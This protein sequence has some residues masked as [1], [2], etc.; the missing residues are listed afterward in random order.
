MGIKIRITLDLSS[1]NK[2]AGGEWSEIFNV[3]DRKVTNLESFI[4]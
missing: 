2:Q 1:E 3:E 4:Q